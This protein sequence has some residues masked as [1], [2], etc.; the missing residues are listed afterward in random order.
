RLIVAI[1]TLSFTVYLIPGLWGAPLRAISGFPPPDFYKEWTSTTA[2]EG[3]GGSH[4]ETC[5]HNL[6]CFHDYEEGM[7]YAQQV[8]KPVMIDFTGWSCVN[9]RKMEDNVWSQPAVLKVISEDYVLISLYVDDKTPLPESKQFVST[10]TNKKVKSTGNK[11]SE[12]QSRIYQTNS[13]P[14]YVLLDHQ[15]KLLA[16]PVGYTPDAAVYKKY[17]EEGKCRFKGRSAQ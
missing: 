14:Y 13:Q 17:L 2:S 6:N 12:M 15:G 8:G 10:S 3:G 4:S 16:K 1:I 11:W 5:P 7:A 9:C